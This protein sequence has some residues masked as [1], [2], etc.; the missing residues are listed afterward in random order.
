MKIYKIPRIKH[1]L[2]V[3]T[4]AAG[5]VMCPPK[6]ASVNTLKYDTF[7]HHTEIPVSP[8]MKITAIVPP[9]GT[10]SAEILRDAPPPEVEILGKTKTAKIFVDLTNNILYKY[11]NEGNAE[12]A[13]SVAS[14]KESTPTRTGVRVVS[15]IEDYPFRGAPSWSKRRR[16]PSAYGPKIIILD[17]INPETG[18][19]WNNGEFIHGTNNPSSIGK[20]IS[21]GC[22]RMDNEV[23]KELAGEVK[24]G[25]IVVMRK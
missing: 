15:H 13:Y 5:A 19:K 23:I 7:E 17:M 22:V 18:E 21:H 4:L 8:G 6:A 9:E 11:D 20:H 10:A 3:L 14:G 24:R 2:G 25:D 16:S 1:A 12:A